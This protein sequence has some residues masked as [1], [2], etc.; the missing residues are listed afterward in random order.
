[1]ILSKMCPH[2][3]YF[4]HLVSTSVSGLQSVLQYQEALCPL[5]SERER[6]G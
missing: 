3:V 2:L 1:M 6:G 4:I 5:V